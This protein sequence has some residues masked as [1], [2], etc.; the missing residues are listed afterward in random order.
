MRWAWACVLLR[1]ARRRFEKKGGVARGSVETFIKYVTENPNLFRVLLGERQGGSNTFQ[2][3]LHLEIKRFVVDLTVDLERESRQLKQPLE[4]AGL[5]AEAIVAVAFTV[6]A[7]V[8]ELPKSRRRE[9]IERIIKE[10]NM[11][12]RGASLGGR[13]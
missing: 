12:L 10:V 13:R 9:L 11:I 5:A 7:E 8:L 3:A 6:G 2:K 1:A 4:E